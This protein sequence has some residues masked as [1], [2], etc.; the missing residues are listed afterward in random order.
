M[1]P[2]WPVTCLCRIEPFHIYLEL[3]GQ[4][5]FTVFC[6]LEALFEAVKIDLKVCVKIEFSIIYGG[7]F[8]FFLL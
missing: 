8:V 6:L 4:K 1:L 3:G 2:H 7:H 5:I